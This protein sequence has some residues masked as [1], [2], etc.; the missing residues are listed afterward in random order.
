MSNLTDGSGFLW[1]ISSTGYIGNGTID[2]YDGGMILAGFPSSTER[3]EDNG[4]EV[5]LGPQTSGQVSV[6]RKI[7]VPATG[8]GF[9]RFLEI[10]TNTGTTATTYQVGI[11]TNLGSDSGTVVVGTSS[12]DQTFNTADRWI[13]TDDFSNGGGDPTVAHVIGN[14][15]SAA[16]TPGGL[17]Y[18]YN[19]SLNPGQTR[20]VMHF[21]VQASNQANARTTVNSLMSL[22]SAVYAGMS[23]AEI[24][25]VVNFNLR[26]RSSQSRIK[27]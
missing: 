19:L 17:N 25:Q 10:V 12:G 8:T 22:P 3:L 24:A 23:A 26:Y 5:V 7:Y 18:S 6:T 4:R 27:R 9:A 1:D 21:G 2:A 11:S 14:A 16:Y 15:S 20:I 13:I